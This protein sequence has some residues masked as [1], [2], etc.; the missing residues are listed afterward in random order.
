V[1]YGQA[2]EQPTVD[3]SGQTAGQPESPPAIIERSS[4]PV[5]DDE[6][7]WKAKL[8]AV[9]KKLPS[10][11]FT[12]VRQ[13]PFIVIG[14]EA[15]GTVRKR[16]RSTVKWSVDRLKELYFDKDPDEII[17]VW[18]FK[19]GESYRTHAWTLFQDKPDTPYGYYSHTHNALIMNI[20]TGGGTLVHEI[21]HPFMATN[22]LDCP[23]WFNEGMGSLYEQSS[24]R[25]DHIIGLTNWRLAGL[26]QAIESDSVPLFETLMFTTE[27]EFYDEDPGTN[28]AQARYLCYYLQE[29]DLLY[30]YY[31]SFLQNRLTDPTGF[32]TLKKTLKQDDLVEFQKEWEQWV[33]KLQFP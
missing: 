12:V 9:H 19:D 27:R 29:H 20:A 21:V 10:S 25:N 31:H 8:L 23:A 15:P 14:D 11:D 2:E 26:Q 7:R 18:L 28:Y 6:A 3:V 4:R 1:G 16:A 5:P 13:D 33:M 17:E 24:Q 22:F 30:K 32:S